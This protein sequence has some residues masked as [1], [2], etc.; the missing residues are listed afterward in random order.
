MKFFWRMLR[1]WLQAKVA[2]PRDVRDISRIR[3]R[4]RAIDLDVQLHMNNGTYLT[5][6][7]LGRLDYMLRTGLWN[8]IRELGWY[9]VVARQTIAYRKSLALG[10]E[11]ELHT[12][13]LGMDDRNFYIEHRFVKDG[14][15][16]AQAFVL[17]RFTGPNGAIS[18]DEVVAQLHEAADVP[19]TIPQWVLEWG[20]AARVPSTRSPYPSE[21]FAAEE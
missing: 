7:D 8:R 16:Y 13:Y 9:A 6:Q 2:R 5:I 11:Y 18:H 21:W 15:I 17:G 20:E 1:V 3:M 19:S 10:D 12:R 14:E 4:V